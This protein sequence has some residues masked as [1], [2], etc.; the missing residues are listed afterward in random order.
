MTQLPVLGIRAVEVFAVRIP[1]KRPV[2]HSTARYLHRDYV[3]AR[4]RTDGG[5]DGLAYALA[6][7]L[8]AAAIQVV[9]PRLLEL[10][11]S[12]IQ[13]LH[14]RLYQE[15][16]LLGRRG[17]SMIALSC[18]DNALWDAQAKMLGVPVFE[19]FDL[20]GDAFPVAAGAGLYYDDDTV[21]QAARDCEKVAAQGF[22]AL[23]IRVGGRP[24]AEDVQRVA[25]IR[26]AIGPEA[27]LMMNANMAWESADEAQA[28]LNRISDYDVEWCAEPLDPDNWPQWR[29][30]STRS[31][32][33]LATGEQESGRWA[34]ERIIA[35]GAVAAM[36]PDVT[37][38]GGVS[39]WKAIAA[40]AASAG[41]PVV[42]HW[43]PDLHV[44]LVR[45]APSI[46]WLEYLPNHAMVNLDE[47]LAEHLQPANGCIA[48]PDRPGFGLTFD[49]DAVD[50]YRI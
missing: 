17:V 16:R 7:P 34:F 24:L 11:P 22:K 28:F 43:S 25:A 35:D 45:L 49:W 48:P 46:G 37:R 26:G 19:L 29:E 3:I 30:L 39:E 5:E 33:P 1:L 27:R 2:S 40:Q 44:H 21:A 14:Q 36:Q 31:Q 23:K 41:M 50:R 38:V 9:T 8:V 20:P 6:G 10:G 42:P 32:V 4:V 15:L 47:V 18:L 13:S 12:T